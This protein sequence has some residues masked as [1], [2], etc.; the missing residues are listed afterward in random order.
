MDEQAKKK[1]LR[2]IPYGLF[3]LTAKHGEDVS[4]ATVNWVTQ[5]SFN[6]PLVAV[7]IKC[8]SHPYA[9]VKA[10]G[11]FAI[12]VL[13]DGQKDIA[14]AFFMTVRPEGN[15]LGPVT[16]APGSTGA[17]VLN[18]TPAYWE[19][20]L[21]DVVEQGD[22]HVFL[23]EVV[24]AGVNADAPALLMRDTGWNYGG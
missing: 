6:P 20:R 24:N 4:G 9:T 16:F 13:A 19:C 11:Y 15:K 10:A 7:A 8:D 14:Q 22:H 1:S 3:V 21:L 2:M 17:P 18:E 23:G 12:N 5:T